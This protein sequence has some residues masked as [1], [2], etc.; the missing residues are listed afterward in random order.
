M[1]FLC[2]WAAMAL[3]A[4]APA[5]DPMAVYFANT[6]LVTQP[7]GE[8]DRPLL[9]PDHTYM[10]HGVRFPE[11]QAAWSAE[12]GQVCL[13]AGDTP[14]RRGERFP[15]R[16]ERRP[17]GRPLGDNGGGCDSANGDRR[18]TQGQNPV[19]NTRRASSTMGV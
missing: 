2:V 1:R 15:Q 3:C 18:G 17:H 16:L 13:I 11:G 19:V 7:W 10:M 14:E 5:P 9:S 12:N 4:C 8:T 6:V